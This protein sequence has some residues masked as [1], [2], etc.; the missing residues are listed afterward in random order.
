MNKL[1]KINDIYS[2]KIAV[3][4]NDVFVTLLNQPPKEEWIK[5]HPF[6][7]GYKYLP[8]ERVE[9]LLKTIFKQYRIEILREGTSFNGV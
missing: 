5:V 7:K 1:P 8:I 4:K 6:I 9:Y 3:Q 2:D